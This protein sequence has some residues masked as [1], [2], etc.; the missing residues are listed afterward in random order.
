MEYNSKHRS[1]YW[2]IIPVIET[3]R[4]APPRGEIPGQGLRDIRR[5]REDVGLAVPVALPVEL[6]RRRRLGGVEV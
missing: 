5:V 3:W 1:M 2:Y 4:R 6:G